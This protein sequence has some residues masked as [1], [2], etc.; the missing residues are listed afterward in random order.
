MKLNNRGFA[1]STMMYLVLVM[2]ILLIVITL[3][4]LGNRKVILDNIKK[5]AQ[6]QIY[7]AN[8][9]KQICKPVKESEYGNVPKGFF[10]AGDEYICKVNDNT[11]YNFYVLSDN[12]NGTINLILDHAITDSAWY[13]VSDNASGP[14]VALK[15]LNDLTTTW[16]NIDNISLDFEDENYDLTTLLEGT[17]TSGY[18]SITTNGSKTTI[19]RL[20]NSEVRTFTNLKARLLNM[21]ELT[22]L[23]CSVKEDSCPS[24]LVYNNEGEVESLHTLSSLSASNTNV[25]EVFGNEGAPYLKSTI[26]T[27]SLSI[28]PVITIKKVSVDASYE[29]RVITPATTKTVTTGNI[30]EGNF[31]IGDEYI[32][33]VDGINSFHFFVLSTDGDYVNLIMNRNILESGEVAIEANQGQVPWISVLDYATYNTDET[34]C[35]YDACNDEGPV[36]AIKFLHNATSN[37]SN[38]P[39]INIEHADAGLSY[40]EIKTINSKTTI[41][42]LDGT[43]TGVEFTDL[44][45][46]LPFASELEFNNCVNGT[47]CN[48][49]LTEYLKPSNYYTS[50]K[51]LS[52]VYGYWTMDSKKSK[53]KS[54]IVFHYNGRTAYN[55]SSALSATTLY[56]VRPVITLTRSDF[57]S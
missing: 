26:A 53:P 17:H 45:A 32:I 28:R 49:W 42:R 57:N 16:S 14:E 15:N 27:D 24:W 6:T 9:Y 50:T 55:D 54:A 35:E 23:G 3:T 39:N 1:I 48:S 20:D 56:G 38:I 13:D 18:G 41:T 5:Q 33:N 11:S 51:T 46:R 34:T 44:K 19:Y 52:G 29:Y 12:G 7:D 2:A 4:L 21:R 30:P 47:I 10:E 25:I 22:K 37:W 40:G 36:T 43:I 31:S 8:I